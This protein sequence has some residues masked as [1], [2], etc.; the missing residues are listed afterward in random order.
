[1]K[2]WRRQQLAAVHYDGSDYA[3]PALQWEKSSF[4]QPQMMVEDRYLFDSSTGRYTVGKYLDDLTNRYGGIDSVLV[5]PTYPN[6]GVD[7]RNTDGMMRCMPGAIAGVRAM[8]AEFHRHHVRVLFPIHPWDVGT[9]DPG[10]PWGTVLPQ[11]MAEVNADGLNGDTMDAVTGDY[12]TTAL[13]LNHPLALEPELGLQGGEVNQLAWNTMNWGY[14]TTEQFAPLVST[15][16]WLEP[17]M[18]VNVCDRWNTNKTGLIQSAFFNGCGI[19]TWENVFGI[20][21][22]MTDRDCEAVRR[23]A[24]IERSFPNLLCSPDWEPFTPVTQYDVVFSSKWPGT[25]KTLWTLVNRGDSEI[26]GE[27]LRVPNVPGT[28]YYDLWHGT[29]LT[30][31]IVNGLVSLSFPIEAHGYGAVLAIKSGTEGP[32]LLQLLATMHRLSSRPLSTFAERSS[33]LQQTLTPIAPTAP[34]RSA[35][36]GMVRVPGGVF[37]FQV[38]GVECEDNGPGV[39]FQ[40]PWEHEPVRQ[41]SHTMSIHTFYIDRFPVT[42]EQYRVF[43]VSSGYTPRDRFN[44]LKDWTN[45]V[46]PSGWGNRPVTW[47]SL[48]DARAYAA[49]A[50]KRL[51]HEWEWQYAAGGSDG[52]LYPWGSNWDSA[53][54][55]TPDTGRLLTEPE[56]VDS[57]ADISPFGVRDLIGNVWQWTDEYT[58][59]H[60]R[61]AVL[62]GGSYYQPQGSG[63]YFP[64]AY[65][66]DQHGKYLLMSPGRDRS[67]TIGFR[68]V[69]DAAQ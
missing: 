66:L 58:D 47:V 8:V 51:P 63:Y 67:G 64:Q 37:D 2:L 24:A 62:R 53:M 32:A 61:A 38:S 28:T 19:E 54:V 57:S 12:M 25:G 69:V 45:G 49:W 23:V 34:A 60:T 29:A 52:R 10:A 48:D 39:D 40:Y 41:H 17:R 15:Y 7:D 4:I 21:N 11:S 65:R 42:N 59:Q 31:K 36:A 13:S 56:N 46:Y 18:M 20:W 9:R 33:L 5:W 50:H 35:P 27:Q 55:P 43:I 26:T 30:P 1:M 14:W 68:C 3:L 16:K 6:M 44:F 22:G